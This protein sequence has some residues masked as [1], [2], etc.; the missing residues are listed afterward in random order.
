MVDGSASKP[1][2]RQDITVYTVCT[3]SQTWQQLSPPRINKIHT[4]DKTSGKW[5]DKQIVFY[6]IINQGTWG[7]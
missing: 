7:H 6:V 1:A 2:F 3:K 5:R 4:S